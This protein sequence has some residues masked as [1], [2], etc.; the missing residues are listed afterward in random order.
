[1]SDQ[2]PQLR[3]VRHLR[4]SPDFCVFIGIL[5][6]AL[7]GGRLPWPISL[8]RNIVLLP[9]AGVSLILMRITGFNVDRMFLELGPYRV[10]FAGVIA[11]YTL[12]YFVVGLLLT[13]HVVGRAISAV[14]KRRWWRIVLD[15]VA[16]SEKEAATQ[17][18]ATPLSCEQRGSALSTH[19]I[20]M[21]F[22]LAVVTIC[23]IAF[24]SLNLSERTSSASYGSTLAQKTSA[25]AK[26]HGWPV[27]WRLQEMDFKPPE[28][29]YAAMLSDAGGATVF[30]AA[31]GLFVHRF[32]QL[33][34][35]LTPTS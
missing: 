2:D 12:P 5:L 20:S 23:M 34:L 28:W 8:L 19:Q 6:L 29:N 7:F 17:I 3:L 27:A 11:A 35:K 16:R 26:L 21:Y 13:S 18:P 9:V 24:V 22:A 4:I 33:I 31:C 32:S 10:L 15:K 14:A 25:A 30:A 1:M